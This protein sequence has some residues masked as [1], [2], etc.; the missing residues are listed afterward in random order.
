ML[1]KAVL[2]N[3]FTYSFGAILARIV[4]AIISFT[5]ITVFST[6]EFGLMSLF[7]N[8]IA[9]TP[10]FLNL[11]LRQLF[12]LEFFHLD[13]NSKK[14]LF[15]DHIITIYLV[16]SSP[17]LIFFLLNINYLN[18]I[19]FLNEAKYL[20]ILIALIICFFSFF[21]E[22]FFQ[23]LRYQTRAKLLTKIQIQAALIN[24]ILTVI[25]VFIFKFKIIGVLIANLISILFINLYASYLYFKKFQEIKKFNSNIIKNPSKAI[26]YLKLSIPL[27]SNIILS[28]TLSSSD[29]WILAHWGNLKLVGIYAVADTFGHLFNLIILQPLGGS[30]VPY[31]LEKFSKA[32]NY[33]EF[34]KINNHNLK[35][36]L[37]TV[38]GMLSL[39]SI[40][41]LAFK[42]IFLLVAPERYHQ[43]VNYILLILMGQTFFMGTY[44]SSCILQYQK[45]AYLLLFLTFTSSII[46]IVLNIILIPNHGIYG[47]TI[48]TLISYIIYFLLTI[49]LSKI[50]I[51]KYKNN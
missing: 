20:S 16:I 37:I 49:F 35:L 18:K 8:F 19:V 3:F 11:G 28:W 7:N 42:P 38:T 12:G 26:R 21:S 41:Y 31:I 25:L 40:G 9:I 33:L 39:I 45:R 50:Y 51:N 24:A 27:I 10:I 4:T 30:Y 15:L 5:T 43:S 34:S 17:V 14:R 2:K 13:N 32:K 48:A 36:M 44:F 23:V 47:C 29:R 1:N 46:N 22:L 6:S